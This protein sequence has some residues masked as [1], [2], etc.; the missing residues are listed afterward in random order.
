MSITNCCI[1]KIN[2]KMQGWFQNDV[3]TF[4]GTKIDMTTSQFNFNQKIK[5]RTYFLRN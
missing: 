2:A 4:K 1:G 5:E 3:A